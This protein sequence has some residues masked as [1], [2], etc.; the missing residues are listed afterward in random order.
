MRHRPYALAANQYHLVRNGRR[1][2]TAPPHPDLAKPPIKLVSRERPQLEGITKVLVGEDSHVSQPGQVACYE[3]FGVCPLST[4]RTSFLQD[5]QN[6]TLKG[7]Q[8]FA[9]LQQKS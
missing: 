2:T 9:A 7:D 3:A 1:E 6:A 4:W 8:L 5:P